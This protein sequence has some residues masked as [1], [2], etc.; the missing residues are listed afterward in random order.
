MPGPG[1][2]L[3]DTRPH[4]TTIVA[5]AG[6]TL[7]LLAICLFA[8]PLSPGSW[9]PCWDSSAVGSWIAGLTL[10]SSLGTTGPA[11]VGTLI[12]ALTVVINLALTLV[13]RRSTA[14]TG[15]APEDAADAVGTQ[16]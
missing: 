5:A 6:A 9:S 4:A 10:G 13:R 16:A 14:F 2:G 11:V 1:E 7:L 3:G 8:T 15:Q 12:A